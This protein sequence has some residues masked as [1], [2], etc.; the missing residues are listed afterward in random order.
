MAVRHANIPADPFQAQQLFSAYYTAHEGLRE[1]H[2]TI[3]AAWHKISEN[4]AVNTARCNALLERTKQQPS[5]VDLKEAVDLVSWVPKIQE[6]LATTQQKVS[7]L[8]QNIALGTQFLR[9]KP[10]PALLVQPTYAVI[11][12]P[13]K[14]DIQDLEQWDKSAKETLN[15]TQ[16]HARRLNTLHSSMKERFPELPNIAIQKIDNEPEEPT[17]SLFTMLEKSYEAAYTSLGLQYHTIDSARAQVLDAAPFITNLGA[18]DALLQKDPVTV[19]ASTDDALSIQNL[20]QSGFASMCT[21]LKLQ[22]ENLDMLAVNLVES[23][24]FL[25]TQPIPLFQ[26]E[27]GKTIVCAPKQEHLRQLNSW[28]ASTLEHLKTIEKASC[29]LINAENQMK[30]NFSFQN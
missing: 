15:T 21:T 11:Y 2:E 18:I 5:D 13:P 3:C 28:H 26:L 9:N 14:N 29:Y 23:I 24:K 12:T 10:I 7:M 1:Q 8:V 17:R 27:P 30:T 6:T 4:I 20:L 25:Q 22:Q 16:E 19:R